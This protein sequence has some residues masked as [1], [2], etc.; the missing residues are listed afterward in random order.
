[1]KNSE[2]MMKTLRDKLKELL[3]LCTPEQQDVFRRMYNFHGTLEF[4]VDNIPLEKMDTA[5]QQIERTLEKNRTMNDFMS[6]KPAGM[7]TEE[8]RKWDERHPNG[9][10]CGNEYCRCSQ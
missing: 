9:G 5:F 1:M 3:A 2:T 7:P 8:Q 10:M 6:N 4:S